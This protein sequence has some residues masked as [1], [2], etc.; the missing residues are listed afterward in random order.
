MMDKATSIIKQYEEAVSI[1]DHWREKFEE[2]YE[3][4]L[5]NRE[6]FYE[7]SPGQRR[8]DKIF[9]ET[10]VTI[11]GKTFQCRIRYD[12]RYNIRCNIQ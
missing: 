6:S 12:I 5:P 9:D 4:C 1:K 10:W 2:A 8:T 7:E 3:Y 11:F